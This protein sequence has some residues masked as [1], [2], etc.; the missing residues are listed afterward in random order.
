MNVALGI[1]GSAG[2][3]G[4]GSAAV[5]VNNVNNTYSTDAR[6][7]TLTQLAPTSSEVT[8]AAQW[9]QLANTA[10][11]SINVVVG[12]AGS[13]GNFAAAGSVIV[14]KQTT[15]TSSTASYL[16]S[17]LM[18]NNVLAHNDSKNVDVAG[19]IAVALNSTSGA[20][21]A[22]VVVA[23]HNNAATAELRDSE[24]HRPS[25]EV[26]VDAQNS[27]TNIVAAVNGG[28]SKNASIS[29]S[30][31]VNR[32]TND[33]KSVV[34]NITLDRTKK[35]TATALDSSTTK[36][37]SGALAVSMNLQQSASVAGAVSYAVSDGTTEAT[38]DG[39]KSLS[40]TPQLD[41][42]ATGQDTVQTLTI[43]GTVGG[44]SVTGAVGLNTINRHV[45]A[46]TKHLW[47][48]NTTFENALITQQGFDTVRVSAKN[49]S[50]IGNL[51]TMIAFGGLAGVGA[52]VSKNEIGGDV[53]T[54]VALNKAKVKSLEALASNDA[55][56]DTIGVGGSGSLQGAVAGSVSLN[57]L[58]GSTRMLVSDNTLTV[59]DAA[60]FNALSNQTM[61]VYSGTLAAGGGLAIGVSVATLTN[62]ASVSNEWTGT[63]TVTQAGGTG[64]LSY[65]GRVE[66]DDINDAIVEKDALNTSATLK[67]KLVDETING[68]YVG[69]SSLATYK[70]LAINIAG[71]LGTAA[72]GTVQLLTHD[73]STATSLGAAQLNAQNA[74]KVHT[75]DYV[76]NTSVQAAA[77]A[78]T[79]N[80]AGVLV[81]LN[82]SKREVST[83]SNGA[84]LRA[85]T[86]TVRSE[87]KEGLSEL[88]FQAAG[89]FGAAGSVVAGV[90]R[91]STKVSTDLTNSVLT[92]TNSLTVDS[93]YLHR[94]NTLGIAASASTG[95]AAAATVLVNEANNQVL[96]SLTHSTLLGNAID[97]NAHRKLDWDLRGGAGSLSF[98]SFAL[99]AMVGVNTVE[100]NTAVITK[101]G[102]QIGNGQTNSVTVNA[103][104]EDELTMTQASVSGSLA[105]AALAGAVLVN[106]VSDDATL[107]LT[108]TQIR[109]N[110]VVLSATQS[111]NL[112]ARSAAASA[113]LKLAL[114]ANVLV[115]LV[116][117]DL[118]SMSDI[119]T[120]TATDDRGEAE[121]SSSWGDL[122]TTITEAEATG[123]GSSTPELSGTGLESYAG[124]VAD[125][126]QA[127]ANTFATENRFKGTRVNLENAIV[128]GN[129][130]MTIHALEDPKVSGATSGMDLKTGGLSAGAVSLGASVALAE[131][132]VGAGVQLSG[133]TISAPTG[134]LKVGNESKDLVEAIQGSAGLVSGGAGFARLRVSGNATLDLTNGSTLEGLDVQ[135]MHAGDQTVKATGMIAGG[136]A[137]GGLISR[138]EDRA[139]ANVTVTNSTFKGNSLYAE[140]SH[141]IY[142]EASVGYGGAAA[143]VGADSKITDTG[144]AAISFMNSTVATSP[145]QTSSS[146]ALTTIQANNRAQLRVYAGAMGGGIVGVGVPLA[147]IEESG[148]ANLTFS[149]GAI[150]APNVTLGAVN[151]TRTLDANNLIDTTKAL[152]LTGELEG[153][154]GGIVYVNYN[155]VKLLNNATS[156]FTLTNVNFNPNTQLATLGGG[157]TYFGADAS[158]KYGGA[159]TAGSNQLI[160]NN[161]LQST[162]TLTGLAGQ[163]LGNLDA[164]L[165]N[166]SYVELLGEASG[167]ALVDIGIEAINIENRDTSSN[168]LTI[169]GDWTTQKDFDVQ[170]VSDQGSTYITAD[171]TKGSLA[172]LSTVY[173][174][175]EQGSQSTPAQN[176]VAVSDNAHI[177]AGENITLSSAGIWGLRPYSGH[178]HVL[179]TEAHGLLEA[180]GA[181]LNQVFNRTNVVDIGS[182]SSLLASA[183]SIGLEAKSLGTAE[184]YAQS[185]SAAGLA[186]IWGTMTSRYTFTNQVNVNDGARLQT[187]SLANGDILLGANAVDQIN[188]SMSSRFEGAA[189]ATV[190]KLDTAYTRN[191]QINV[192]Q[193]AIVDSGANVHL[194]A[195]KDIRGEGNSLTYWSQS[196]AYAAAIAAAVSPKLL[197]STVLN[198]TLNVA[199]KV[200]STKS[201]ELY[202]DSGYYRVTEDIDKRFWAKITDN[203]DHRTAVKGGRSRS[204]IL[205][206]N[207]AVNLTGEVTAGRLTKA[208]ITIGNKAYFIPS[209]GVSL[210]QEYFSHAMD[211]I[212][213]TTDGGEELDNLVKS[214]IGELTPESMAYL[215][216]ERITY[217]EYAIN[218]YLSRAGSLTAE[219]YAILQGFQ[220]EYSALGNRLIDMG[221]AKTNEER[222]KVIPLK[223]SREFFI[224]IHD[225]TV[226]GGSIRITAP[227]VTGAG[228]IKANSAQG[229]TITNKSNASL[230]LNNVRIGEKGGLLYLNDNAVS[231]DA[232]KAASGFGGTVHYAGSTADPKLTVST[233]WDGGRLRV[234]GDTNNSSR[235]PKS[236]IVISGA[237]SNESGDVNLKAQGDIF[238]QDTGQL[239]A[240]GKMNLEAGGSITQSR[241]NHTEVTDGS[242]L[243]IGGDPKTGDNAWNT[244]IESVR[245]VQGSNQGSTYN[246]V[247]LSKTGEWV[248]GGQIYISGAAINLNGFIQSGFDRYSWDLER[249]TNSLVLAY[250]EN[251]HLQRLHSGQL[252]TWNPER[253]KITDEHKIKD[254]SRGVYEWVP[255]AWLD[256]KTM[257]VIVDDI[258]PQTSGVYI[259]GSLANTG[260]GKIYVASGKVDINLDT[261]TGRGGSVPYSL[262]TRDLVGHVSPGVIHL[263]DTSQALKARVTHYE[264]ATNKTQTWELDRYGNE[265]SGTRRY[266]SNVFQP[267]DNLWYSWAY[268]ISTAKYQSV[269]FEEKRGLWGIWWPSTSEMTKNAP[270]PVQL[271]EKEL[272]SRGSI[273]VLKNFNPTIQDVY[274]ANLFVSNRTL[275]SYDTGWV[276]TDYD[277]WE[278][279][280]LGWYKHVYALHER[281]DGSLD[282]KTFA[283]RATH[284]VPLGSL[285]KY[286]GNVTLK[287]SGH[288]NLDGVVES[289]LNSAITMTA[290]GSINALGSHV[291]LSNA[292]TYTLTGVEG[293]GSKERALM[294]KG[295][296]AGTEAKITATST[297]GSIYLDGS[298]RHEQSGQTITANA[299]QMLSVQTRGNTRFVS[300]TAQDFDLS[301]T[302]GNLTID[303]FVQKD[304]LSKTQSANIRVDGGNLS[305]TALTG[306]IGLGYVTV[307]GDATIEARQGTIYDAVAT[308][309][310]ANVTQR[311]DQRFQAW[312]RAGLIDE[313]G[314]TLGGE[315]QWQQDYNRAEETVR[316]EF[317]R[318]QLWLG[319]SEDEQANLRETNP[320]MAANYSQ[321]ATKYEGVNSA[322]DAVNQAKNDPTSQL[323]KLIAE[324]ANYVG[325]TED[326][327]LFS[328]AESVINP[329]ADYTVP[330]REKKTLTVGGN[331]V[332]K[333]KGEGSTIGKTNETVTGNIFTGDREERIKV[334]NALTMADVSD[335]K[336]K[337]DGT[338]TVSLK[339]PVTIETNRAIDA[340][341]QSD[342]YLAS[343]KKVTVKSVISD[344]GEARLIGNNGIVGD[345]GATHLVQGKTIILR[346][347]IGELTGLDV[348]TA[349]DNT[350]WA[351]I[352]AGGNID[353]SAPNN[354]ILYALA[355]GSRVHIT[356][357]N[358]YS[359]EG[360]KQD[361]SS[362]YK[363]F[364]SFG[365]LQGPDL[366]FRIS[367][368]FGT[369]D[370]PL[371]VAA[372]SV[373]HF[374]NQNKT[375]NGLVDFWTENLFIH[376][377]GEGTL[378]IDSAWV[379]GETK[380]TSDDK[381]EI[382]SMGKVELYPGFWTTKSM[383]IKS[384][385]FEAKNDL[386]VA[387]NLSSSQSADDPTESVLSLKSQEGDVIFASPYLYAQALDISAKNGTIRS[388]AQEPS[389]QR[390]HGL[391]TVSADTVDWHGLWYTNKTFTL[392]TTGDVD[393][394][395]AL[396]SGYD[397]VSTSKMTIGGD[398]LAQNAT[399]DFTNPLPVT[400]SGEVNFSD[401]EL[402]TGLKVTTDKSVLLD[403]AHFGFLQLD[404]TQSG[405]TISAKDATY[406]F[407]ADVNFKADG[408]ITFTN[409]K[410]LLSEEELAENLSGDARF[411]N[412]ESVN[413]KVDLT[414]SSLTST[415]DMTVTAKSG[416]VANNATI[417][418]PLITMTSTEGS[419]E[420]NDVS[421]SA[422]LYSIDL[423]APS[424]SLTDSTLSSLGKMNVTATT[425]DITLTDASIATGNGTITSTL[426]NIWAQNLS[427]QALYQQEHEASNVYNQQQKG[428]LAITAAKTLDV[429]DTDDDIQG[430]LRGLSMTLTGTEALK[431]E[432]THIDGHTDWASGF[433]PKWITDA[434]QKSGTGLYSLNTA[435]SF[436]IDGMT[437]GEQKAARV[438]VNY[439]GEVAKNMLVDGVSLVADTKSYT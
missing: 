166:G 356:A 7:V 48:G 409:V 122:G 376:G 50:Q 107:D 138:A 214:S 392:E 235:S 127:N 382:G 96:T 101:Q 289:S 311:N 320:A 282:L 352:S 155:R 355:G 65:A 358:M 62:N 14:D 331:L 396:I 390:V 344:A 304:N 80:A 419:I 381:L 218:T 296:Q 228:A 159:V 246:Y 334:I 414:D 397:T 259:T 85:N 439:T 302:S 2:K 70:T 152:S 90:N 27:V 420:A 245:N 49:L 351:A 130:T 117:E 266:T 284:A 136:V 393:I 1:A 437:I 399:I 327:L 211:Q 149:G 345:T 46:T 88:L 6:N 434:T 232:L 131:R 298:Y 40:G 35:L 119:T 180:N 398:L 297:A 425:G 290:K 190:S 201:A 204:N 102:S 195:G 113:S 335:F 295:G 98:T 272:K 25:A 317:D 359:Y 192:K 373:I 121:T 39:A 165:F 368:S 83:L 194:Y 243:H 3:G 210:E 36:T 325:W 438:T 153:Y 424:L 283:V 142:S 370:T 328:L 133:S 42:E 329:P 219:E 106:K 116:G 277:T 337:D 118:P 215:Y 271:E 339:R 52:G 163:T 318:A 227:K 67:D 226:S 30:V 196:E 43:A 124:D 198:D 64:T 267:S 181:T 367:E 294:L 160:V 56:I 273:S 89:S 407:S 305:L 268:G 167:G 244:A 411:F 330:L 413:D 323:S 391:R 316:A 182:H 15:N 132:H 59:L 5:V 285:N 313:T 357:E 188:Q 340:W 176:R 353:I 416:I 148:A 217:L 347:G 236:H 47:S 143:G 140:R 72:Q 29:G 134:S 377:I 310:E 4:A 349:Q 312:V 383:R 53:T 162:M 241:A 206:D 97:V 322:E 374:D 78:S 92:G 60:V 348:V 146:T 321:L 199:G 402:V 405:Q 427:A 139:G 34:N 13:S 301:T 291:A 222:T 263:T 10:M 77:A 247:N 191:N 125:N 314:A 380:V 249:D 205:T 361:I 174:T 404:A 307:S 386:I 315:Q 254:A 103:Q 93:D 369:A 255:N 68:I 109:A 161:A 145:Q 326:D 400:V 187:K 22:A 209:D 19:N 150:S 429:S 333:A 212:T 129:R 388:S 371:R 20:I 95:I 189:A 100:G 112:T 154:G 171:N 384:G 104:N 157:Y 336:V 237:V 41:V 172:G 123:S 91:T 406:A 395:N 300:V 76:N 421:L 363:D 364:S 223:S 412:F 338:F 128:T 37:L 242:V 28:V 379:Q 286:S 86:L 147:T 33:A 250:L 350:G 279:G 197:T 251:N 69:A 175:H 126:A 208:N 401:A 44:V 38:V 177:T 114:N 21:G 261:T 224:P 17:Q 287:S 186:G 324:K 428:T 169:A 292:K 8:P 202:A 110:D 216:A 99:A 94:M 248:A 430:G 54:T 256:P 415:L 354:L 274:P 423:K 234:A 184:S 71:S 203:S 84:Q 385:V 281:W 239:Y 26:K 260:G 230:N 141:A 23:D 306:N 108:N 403:G 151:G 270:P 278:S 276:L 408:K 61:G 207:A 178:D 252:D 394:Q 264:A 225:L 12:A 233:Q 45:N 82:N 418:A 426:G 362:E 275:S 375:G 240:A 185:H 183:G 144:V 51:S 253:V 319:L 24:F 433:I 365:I 332:I 115:N 158:A 265:V 308:N 435:G 75:G 341:A 431:A 18:V 309:D 179:T 105:S 343:D 213:V 280:A 258:V 16:N 269:E 432:G 156:A 378:K 346:G 66:N 63:N 262:Q 293:I 81:A 238:S 32:T 436:A 303:N 168:A 221:L 387:S 111:R 389:T 200:A 299:A 137:V 55:D 417:N 74:L 220:T 372:N 422:L 170:S 9:N 57:K 231:A 229:I 31:A 87:A 173:V 360:T 79:G 135:V 73:G 257:T 410:S 58:T 366:N 288:I 193:G 342:L 164:D 11:K 120:L